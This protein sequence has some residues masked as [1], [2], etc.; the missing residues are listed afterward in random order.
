MC[1]LLLPT[2]PSYRY[3]WACLST[4]RRSF[5]LSAVSTTCGFR[6]ISLVRHFYGDEISLRWYLAQSKN[7]G[8]C[9]Y[10]ASQLFTRSSASRLSRQGPRQRLDRPT[11]SVTGH[12]REPVGAR[13][14]RERW[15]RGYRRFHAC[16]CP[17]NGARVRAHSWAVLTWPCAFVHPAKRSSHSTQSSVPQTVFESNLKY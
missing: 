7:V 16:V 5:E 1:W 14:F 12:I 2:G 17:V 9:Y 13:Q 3:T 4:A 11:D 15:G 10:S 6:V 8:S